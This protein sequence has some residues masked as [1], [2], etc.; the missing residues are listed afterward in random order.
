MP[1]LVAGIF[2]CLVSDESIPR[3]TQKVFKRWKDH[4]RRGV[5]NRGTTYARVFVVNTT[6]PPW[7]DLL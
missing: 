5:P 1:S 6:Y 2:G 3:K 4:G 7:G